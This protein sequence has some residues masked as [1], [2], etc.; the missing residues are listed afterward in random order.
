MPRC[1]NNPSSLSTTD[2]N[3]T[4]EIPAYH[5]WLALEL[6]VKLEHDL[7]VNF[8]LDEMLITV[9]EEPLNTVVRQL[10]NFHDIRFANEYEFS[11]LLCRHMDRFLFDADHCNEGAVL[12]QYPVEDTRRCD[13]AILFFNKGWVPRFPVASATDAK[14]VKYEEAKNESRLYSICAASRCNENSRFHFLFSFPCSVKS[15]QMEMHLIVSNRL[16]FIRLGEAEFTNA[17]QLRNFLTLTYGVVRWTF[18]HDESRCSSKPTGIVPKKGLELCN[19]IDE[20]NPKLYLRNNT[21]YKICDRTKPDLNAIKTLEYMESA[22]ID[23]LCQ[24]VYLLSYNFIEGN[25]Q[26]SRIEQF[27]SL[28]N[29]LEQLHENN[30]V[31][32]D[33]RETNLLFGKDDSAYL[34]D[35][36][37][38]S[39]KGSLYCDTYNSNLEER[40][41]DAVRNKQMNPEH[42]WYS[43]IY[44]CKKYFV[45]P[46]LD[47]CPRLA[48]HMEIL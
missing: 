47:N 3:K 41:P 29:L 38:L 10:G 27:E 8:E 16:H 20:N 9:P 21:V 33:V 30:L 44:L 23:E 39:P 2:L 45:H 37:F 28:A 40:H 1:S 19:Y 22:N 17:R 31:H 48:S 15:I 14:L 25:L 6:K 43:L 35:F 26:P 7:S 32:G 12:S 42:D 34:I 18:K 46:S 24:D 11:S 36:D 5:H 13:L 4:G